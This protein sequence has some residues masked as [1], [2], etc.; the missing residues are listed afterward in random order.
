MSEIKVCKSCSGDSVFWTGGWD[1]PNIKSYKCTHCGSR[2]Q[3]EFLDL[4]PMLS[5]VCSLCKDHM[6]KCECEEIPSDFEVFPE[7]E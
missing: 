4:K 6:D 7:E 1:L 5:E 3:P 2:E